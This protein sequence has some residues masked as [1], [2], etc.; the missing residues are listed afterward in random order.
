MNKKTINKF[1]NQIFYFREK[2][3]IMEKILDEELINSEKK[4]DINSQR[5]HICNCKNTR[6]RMDKSYFCRSCG[7][8]SKKEKEL[9]EK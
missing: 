4:V 6:V 1:M 2:M 5:C 7:F 3:N 8:D 9:E